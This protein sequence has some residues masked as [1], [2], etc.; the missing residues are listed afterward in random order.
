[1]TDARKRL[2]ERDRW[3]EEAVES[4]NIGDDFPVQ[5]QELAHEVFQRVFG[6]FQGSLPEL[7][8]QQ[9]G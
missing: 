3:R 5:P 9:A 2:A 4:E 8:T 1:M 7:T 6:F